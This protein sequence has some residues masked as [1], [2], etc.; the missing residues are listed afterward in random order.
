MEYLVYECV[1]GQLQGLL[2]SLALEFHIPEEEALQ[3]LDSEGV[4]YQLGNSSIPRCNELDKREKRCEARIWNG[5][6]GAR[7]S[8]T[9]INGSDFCTSHSRLKYPR[10]CSGCIKDFK[11]ARHHDYEWQHLGRWNDPLPK[12]ILLQQLKTSAVSSPHS[13]ET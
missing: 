8:R 10:L 13:D 4:W 5:G 6:H 7:C 1:H 12:S 11:E 2:S 3:L 9:R